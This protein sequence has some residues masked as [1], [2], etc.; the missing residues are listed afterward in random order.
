M[1]QNTAMEHLNKAFELFEKYSR[2]PYTEDLV[3][4]DFI[5]DSEKMLNL[6]VPTTYLL[7]LKRYGC[8]GFFGRDF[9]GI[10]PCLFKEKKG[11]EDLVSL[12]DA[13]NITLEKRQQSQLPNK[14]IIVGNP[15]YGPL[16]AIDTS[17]PDE[18]GECPVVMIQG[19]LQDPITKED[20]WL[21]GEKLAPDFGTYL[22]NESKEAL[23]NAIDSGEVEA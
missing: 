4:E 13:F 7:F 14:Y 9:F 17:K 10:V 15:G 11:Y 19:I 3:S 8:Y 2:S 23:Q 12:Y 16:D 18:H 1:K 20:T 22:Y 6:K 21:E 5:K